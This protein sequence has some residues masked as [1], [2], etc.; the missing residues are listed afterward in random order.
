MHTIYLCMHCNS[1]GTY[2][3]NADCVLC[4]SAYSVLEIRAD[5][6]GAVMLDKNSFLFCRILDKNVTNQYIVIFPVLNDTIINRNNFANV[7]H[8]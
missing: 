6:K 8:A 3:A 5:F 1:A 2:A 7:V 4:A